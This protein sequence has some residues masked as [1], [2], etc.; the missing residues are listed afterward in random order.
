VRVKLLFACFAASAGFLLG[1]CAEDDTPP[2]EDVRE[3]L[4]RGA[5]GQGELG[6]INRQ[7]DPYV[8]P[9][10]GSPDAVHQ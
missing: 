6:P 8:N 4:E 2:A 3:H 7:D 9:R 10:E 5:T 1:S